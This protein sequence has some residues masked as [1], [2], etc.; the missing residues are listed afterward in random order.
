MHPRTPG[1]GGDSP[2][3]GH[4]SPEYLPTGLILPGR[5]HP[6]PLVSVASTVQTVL[7][8]ATSPLWAQLSP[9]P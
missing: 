3:A 9:G 6:R 7:S 2:P 5:V 1:S 8:V 4:S